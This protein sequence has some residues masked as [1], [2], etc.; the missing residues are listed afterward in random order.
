MRRDEASTRFL[1]GMR[2]ATEHMRHLQQASIE[3]ALQL[4][5]ALGIGKV[6][7]GLKVEP[8]DG[9]TVSVSPGLALDA[10]GRPIALDAPVTLALDVAKALLVAAYELRSSGL[11]NG[12]PTL[13]ANGAKVEA[14]SAPPPYEDGAV[15]FAEVTRD[16]AGVHVVQKGEWYLP[17]LHHGHSGEFFADAD[18][19]W[20][21]DGAPIG[22]S[23]A[24]QFDSGFVEVGPGETVRLAH[25]LRSTELAVEL[26][27]RRADGVITNRGI[28]ADFWFEIAG[29]DDIALARAPSGE[30][31]AL[32]L[33]VRLWLLGVS[34][35]EARRPIADAGDDLG[36]E[37]GASFNLD[38]GRS[39]ALGARRLAR[40]I[41]TQLT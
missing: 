6:C 31:P 30:A 34:A 25:G 5:E 37:P 7:H 12:V 16:E 19:R 35:E 2:V 22:D 36:V 24:P 33:R 28:G 13:L 38:G 9:G 27:A 23:V 14:R 1:D 26:A 8:E 29:E 40:F 10:F 41:W 32:E 15:P 4:R 20:R 11:V 21:Y 18:G 17:P 3:R 39:R